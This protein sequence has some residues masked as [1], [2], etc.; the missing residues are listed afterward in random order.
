MASG[1]LYPVAIID[2]AS[3]AAL[4]WRLSDT[5]DTRFC[6]DARDE[7]PEAALARHPDA[8]EA[9]PENATIAEHCCG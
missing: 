8:G 2:R 7:A 1:A 5:M 6:L 9:G 3:R 4:A